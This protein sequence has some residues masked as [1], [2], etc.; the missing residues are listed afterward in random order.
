MT[1]EAAD[2]P[3]PT[4]LPDAT[5]AA[6]LA[7]PAAR[8]RMHALTCD[9]GMI[10]SVAQGLADLLEEAADAGASLPTRALVRLARALQSD[11]QEAHR[12]MDHLWLDTSPMRRRGRVIG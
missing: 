12:A 11:A 4:T 2:T 8:K 1:T 7:C 5:R 9:V 10:S 3:S 6:L